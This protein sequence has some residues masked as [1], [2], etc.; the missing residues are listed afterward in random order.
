MFQFVANYTT[1]FTLKM[2]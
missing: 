1:D 2:V